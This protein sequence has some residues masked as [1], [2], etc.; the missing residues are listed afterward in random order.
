MATTKKPTTSNVK[1]QRVN[2][3]PPVPVIPPV[4]EA[5]Q[6]LR[7][8]LL[9]N[10]KGA[11]NS[12]RLAATNLCDLFANVLPEELELHVYEAERL[13]FTSCYGGKDADKAWQRVFIESGYIKPK[14]TTKG[15]T[16][17]AEK[18]AAADKAKAD[19][20]KGRTVDQLEVLATQSR[21]AGDTKQAK[22]YLD[23]IAFAVKQTA[24]AEAGTT[25]AL[26]EAIRAYISKCDSVEKLEAIA[27]LCK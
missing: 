15:A 2:A 22:Q 26:K 9:L 21:K 1:D 3:A 18:R 5:T 7:G 4:S 24:K 6:K 19:L 11:F 23:A 8:E 10:A 14:A 27:K 13:A 12:I 17:K 16:D 25:K 20:V